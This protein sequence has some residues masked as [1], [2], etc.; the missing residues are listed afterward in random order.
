MSLQIA[1]PSRTDLDAVVSHRPKDA[2]ARRTLLLGLASLGVVFGDIGTSPLYA[3]RQALIQTGPHATA[4]A[5]TGVCSLAIWALILLVTVKYLFILL[6]HDAADPTDVF[7][8]PPSRVVE[9]GTQIA[10]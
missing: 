8:L 5:V 4:P 6:S 3:F 7:H 10:A 2:A 1:V 9:R